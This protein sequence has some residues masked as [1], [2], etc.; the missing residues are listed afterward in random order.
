MKYMISKLKKFSLIAAKKL[1]S[2]GWDSGL[3]RDQWIRKKLAEIDPGKMLLDAGAGEQPYKKYCDHIKYTSQ[4]FSQYDGVGDMKGVHTGKFN[5][6]KID[7]VSDICS[8]P[9]QD[10]MFDVILCTEVIEHIPDPL[11]AFS[12]FNRLL[13]SGGILL[14]TAP[15]NSLTHFAPFHFSSGFNK[16]YYEYHL[17]RQGFEII[18]IISSGNFFDYLAQE[19]IRVPGFSKRYCSSGVRLYD[20]I[21]LFLMLKLLE[22]LSRNDS[23]SSESLTFSYFIVAKKI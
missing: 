15:F 21:V 5:T 2:V 3:R 11:G 9:L 19:V 17:P 12:E 16:Y 10:S 6:Q 18:E 13:K 1:I 4:D 20:W 23:G 7:I 14:L 22:R 8:I